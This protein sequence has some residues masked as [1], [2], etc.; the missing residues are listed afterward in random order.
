MVWLINTPS[1][2]VIFGCNYCPNKVRIFKKKHVLNSSEEDIR[3]ARNGKNPSA[4]TKLSA[5]INFKIGDLDGK[6]VFMEANCTR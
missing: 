4:N 6:S 5:R 2:T 1:G 3:N